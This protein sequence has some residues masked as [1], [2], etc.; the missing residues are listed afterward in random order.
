MTL[1]AAKAAEAR[2]LVYDIENSPTLGWTWSRYQ[3]DVLAVEQEFFIMSVAWKFLDENEGHVIG[4]PDFRKRYKADPT[5]D[6]AIVEKLHQLH[7]D[8]DLLI[9]HNGN[10]FDQKKTN[11]RYL[12]HGFP[13]P[14]PYKQID[15][16]LEAKKHFAFSAN[17]LGAL[18]EM[19]GLGGKADN[20]GFG[21]WLSAMRGDKGAWETMKAYNLQDVLLLEQ[22]YL[23]MR[24][25]IAGHPN[26]A[27]LKGTMDGCPKCG[28]TNLTRQG[29]KR[30]MVATR[31]QW[32]CQDCGGWCSSRLA[33]K[34]APRPSLV[35]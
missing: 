16:Y 15:T 3:T 23:R 19:L 4:L 30:T 12:I 8:A 7:S 2:V 18:G 27:M 6:Y 22:I 5:D 14:E 10:S 9:A 11:A 20:G 25:W 1:A 31:Q 13:P 33:D 28:S 26:I 35:N 32:K 21:T 29:Y 17:K 34:D 24:P